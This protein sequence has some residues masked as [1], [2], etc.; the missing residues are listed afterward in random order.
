MASRMRGN[1]QNT[2]A[3]IDNYDSFT[4]N[5]VQCVENLGD[6]CVVVLND[7]GLDALEALEPDAI[8][9]SP[10]PGTPSDAGITLHAIRHFE[11]RIPLL[12]IC[13]GHQALAQHFGARICTAPRPI[14]GKTSLME[15]DGRTVYHG[16]PTPLRV[17]RYHSL[18]VD[19]DTLPECLVTTA[20]SEDGCVMGFR[21]RELPI[22][23]LQFHPESILT[24]HGTT[25]MQNWL[26]TL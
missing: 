25:I 11:G 22:E 1:E 12:G 3:V 15:H 26:E 20:R 17:A 24:P 16:L 13:L 10:G 6:K 14:H 5:L 4:Y 8:L 19:E 9:F 21:H 23:A 2:V 7:V 18:T